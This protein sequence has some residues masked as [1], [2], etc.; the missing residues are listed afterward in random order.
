M[1]NLIDEMVSRFLCWKLP[2][3]FAPDCGISF[4][5]SKAHVVLDVWPTGTNLLHAGQAQEMFRNCLPAFSLAAQDVLAE[6][7]RQVEAEGWDAWHDDKY[8]KGE[9]SDAAASYALNAGVGMRGLRPMFWPWDRDWWKPTT[10]RRDL[11]KAAALILAEI[12]RLDREA[13][14]PQPPKSGD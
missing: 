12:E 2:K 11:V 4:N 8:T 5:P 10:P 7:R 3:D 14:K 1:R 13:T 9:L 6:R